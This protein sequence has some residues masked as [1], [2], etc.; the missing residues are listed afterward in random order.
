MFTQAL[1][2]AEKKIYMNNTNIR[3]QYGVIKDDNMDLWELICKN[4][5]RVLSTE[6]SGYKSI[7]NI[8]ML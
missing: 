1:F 3:K 7:Q 2:V 5:H 6:K 4:T 8:M